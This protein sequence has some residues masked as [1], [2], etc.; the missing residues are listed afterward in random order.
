MP[1]TF[2]DVDVDELARQGGSALRS[3]LEEALVANREY[4]KENAGLTAEKVLGSGSFPLVKPEDLA[5]V[6]VADVESK[7]D[8]LQK[9]RAD[10]QAALARDMLGRKEGLE[11]AALDAAVAEFLDVPEGESKRTPDVSRIPGS[12]VPP[13]TDD[14]SKMNAIEKIAHGIRA[15]DKKNLL[16]R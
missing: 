7:A 6:S 2:E 4:A 10:Q 9:Q 16:G 11:G 14:V 13:S 8:E 15:T 1:V 12:P 3:K 5:D